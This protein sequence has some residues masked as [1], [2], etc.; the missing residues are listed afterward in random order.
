[1]KGRSSYSR[2]RFN[3]SLVHLP[4][5]YNNP[6]PLTEEKLRDFQSLISLMP[7]D[8]RSFYQDIQASRVEHNVTDVASTE[9]DDT[10]DY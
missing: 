5:L 2:D 7:S 3:L 10:L 1:M 6:I 9:E 8:K 4:P